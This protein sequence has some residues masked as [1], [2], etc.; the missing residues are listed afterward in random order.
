MGE[1]VAPNVPLTDPPPTLF[2]AVA[3]SVHVPNGNSMVKALAVTVGINVNVLLG[4]VHPEVPSV[5]VTTMLL[6]WSAWPVTFS[7]S[8]YS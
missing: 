6:A 3:V 7:E 1:E 4:V 8:L 5:A 2:L